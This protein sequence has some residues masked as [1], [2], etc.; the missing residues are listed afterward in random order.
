LETDWFKWLRD[1]LQGLEGKERKRGKSTLILYEC[2]CG[3]KIR[4]G[5]RDW[6]GA[7]CDGCGQPY[8]Q[9]THRTLYQR[10]EAK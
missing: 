8:E 9:K 4:V 6:P 2:P 10:K 3:Q 5:K 1:F 7:H